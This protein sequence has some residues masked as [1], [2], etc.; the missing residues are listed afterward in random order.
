MNRNVGWNTLFFDV[1]NYDPPTLPGNSASLL[2]G[3]NRRNLVIIRHKQLT[4]LVE[5]PLSSLSYKVTA[6]SI[7]IETSERVLRF[8]GRMMYDIKKIIEIYQH[9]SSKFDSEIQGQKMF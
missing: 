8:D 2:L 3:I 5:I 1:S 7:F 9:L 6:F 4:P